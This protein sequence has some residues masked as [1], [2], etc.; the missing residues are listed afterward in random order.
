MSDTITVSCPHCDAALV[1][2]VTAGVVVE[3]RVR[4]AP[5]E[6]VDFEE[7]LRRMEEEKRQ[8]SDRLAEAMRREKSRDRLME[9]RFRSLMDDAKKRKEDGTP[10]IRDIDLD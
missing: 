4:R 6:K 1:I 9:D 3:H 7:R 10:E 8:A 2:D 5:G